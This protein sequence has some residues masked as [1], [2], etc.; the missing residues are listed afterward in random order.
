MN[1]KRCHVLVTGANGFIGKHFCQYLL[2]QGYIVTAVG[3]GPVYSFSHPRLTYHMVASIDGTT[4]WSHVLNGVDVIVHLAARVHQMKDRGMKFLKDYQ[5][6]NVQGT[7]RL[8]ECAIKTVKR[9]VYLSTIKVYGEKTID[10]PFYADDQPRPLDAY[11]VSKLQGEQILQ[12][13]AKRTGMEWVIIRTPLVYGAGVKG[14]FAK[15]IRLAKSWLP[16][17]LRSLKK[18]RSFVSIQ[19]LCHFMTCCLEDS[20]AEREILLVSD[21]EDLSTAKWLKRLRHSLGRRS[22]LLPFPTNVFKWLLFLCGKRRMAN[23]LMEPLQINIEKSKRLLDW[24][25][26]YSVAESIQLLWEKEEIE[27]DN[28]RI[29][30]SPD[31]EC[32]SV[33]DN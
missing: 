13:T 7:Q 26:P 20:R 33:G 6:T 16:L 24:Q 19:N 18:K 8:A 1:H 22:W 11:S 9:F 29:I 3:R 27:T 30:P 23:R 10:M 14:N 21:G 5:V 17:P 2:R 25:P 31:Q 28:F 15:L 12:Q 32:L 4:D